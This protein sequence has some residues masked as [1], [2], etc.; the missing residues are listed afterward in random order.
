MTSPQIK[1]C[2]G[3]QN[4]IITTDNQKNA[5]HVLGRIP[6]IFKGKSVP[7]E[8]KEKLL[9]GMHRTPDDILSTYTFFCSQVLT[10]LV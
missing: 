3:E 7:T 9:L 5:C 8:V 1:F 6:R 10:A 4:F 2:S